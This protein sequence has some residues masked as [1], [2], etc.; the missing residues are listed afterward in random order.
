MYVRELRVSYRRRRVPGRRLLPVE[1]LV[2]PREAALAFGRLLGD[3][4]VEV[5]GMFCLA[6]RGQVLAYHELSRGS[7]DAALVDPREVFK[8]ALLANARSIVLGHNH[9]SGDPEPSAVDLRITE[10]LKLASQLIGIEL[11]DHL[12][13]GAHGYTSMRER[14]TL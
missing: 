7:L 6:A 11:S 13:I 1:H 10:R 8:V 2:G 4:P 3:E 12:V 5:C 14:G 9:P